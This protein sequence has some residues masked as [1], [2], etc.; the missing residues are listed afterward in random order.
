MLSLN[1]IAVCI[2]DLK[3]PECPSGLRSVGL[4]TLVWIVSSSAFPADVAKHVGRSVRAL[5]YNVRPHYC[6]M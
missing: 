5:H 2:A 1:T 6:Q 4:E 3:F